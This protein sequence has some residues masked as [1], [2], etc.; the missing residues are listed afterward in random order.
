MKYKGRMK[1]NKQRF[2]GI[3]QLVFS[4]FA[5]VAVA[6]GSFLF[7][8]Y[9]QAAPETAIYF[10]EVTLTVDN[11][12]SFTLDA[13]IDPGAN[14]VYGVDVAITF[15]PSKVHVTGITRNTTA[16]PNNDYELQNEFDNEEGTAVISVIT[17]IVNPPTISSITTIA[18][19]AFEAVGTGEA[20]ISFDETD[21]IA[22]ATNQAGNTISERTST[23]VTVPDVTDPAGYSVNIN[24]TTI[25]AG[26]DD[27][28]SFTFA[29]AEVGAT[30]NYSIND[31]NGATAAI[32]GTGT[33]ATATDAI[34]NINVTSLDDDTL[35]L[36]VTLTDAALN[37]GDPVTDTVI[38][39]ATL[40]SG[41]TVGF[42]QASITS[43]NE[44]AASFTFAAAEVGAIYNYS[45]NDT[46]GATAAITGTGTIASATQQ[47]SGI[48]VS[49]LDDGTLT[50]TVYL[51]DTF[52]NQ[53][54]N[55][56]DTIAK[57]ADA[58]SGYSVSINQATI[59][60]GNDDALSFTFAA[61]E[62]DATYNYS[63][64]DTNGATA[65]ITGTGTIATATDTISNINVTSLDDGTLTL[66]V[67]LTDTGLNQGGNVTDTVAKDT[68]APAGYSVSINQA[69]INAGNDDALSFTFAA[70]EVGATYNYSIN[71]TNG[72]TAAITGTG[73]IATATD[74]ISNIN[75]TSLDD[76]TLTLT[77]YLT[78]T[79]GNQG[80]NATDTV[81]KDATAPSGYSV[82]INQ[83]TIN[84][85]ND[86]ALSFTFA[87]AEVGATYNYSI[88]DTNGATA[89][90]T[91]TG[92]IA[93]AT[94]TISNINVTSLS[95][96]TLTLTV[97]LTDTFSNQGANTTDTIAKDAVAPSGY[98]VSINQAAINAGNDDALS[99]TFA[100]AEVG[101]SYVYSIN[102]TNGATLPASG[103]GLVAGATQQ[104]SNI[105]V[106]ALD[107]DTLT[108]TVYLI[109]TSLNQ[110]SNVTDTV[111]KD[112]GIPAG[113]SVSFDQDTINAGS[114]DEV[115]FT[116]A[117][118]EVG[119]TYNYSINDTNGATAAITGT[120][121]IA[122]ATDQIADIDVSS[123]DDD[124][125]T[126][127]V[128]LT[129]SAGNQGNNATDTAAK[130]TSV[131]VIAR[132]T[133]V[134]TPTNDT[135][136]RYVFSST[137][138]GDITYGGDCS[139]NTLVAASGN[140]AI[141][142]TFAASAEGTHSNCTITV[143][144]SADNVSNTLNVP[145]FTIDITDPTLTQVAAV[146]TPT[147]DNTPSYTFS[148]DEAGIIT[149]G[150]DCTASTANA[151]IGNNA[152]VFAALSD[153]AHSN[154]TII[155]TDSASNAS[156]TL[157]I[158][159]FTV[160]TAAPVISGGLPDEPET[161]GTVT[162]TLTVTTGEVAVCRYST[163]SDT[164]YADMTDTLTTVG[165]T[166]HTEDV[167]VEDGNYYDYYVRCADPAGNT[168][169]S[170]YH[171]QFSVAEEGDETAPVLEETTPVTT[172]TT[173]TTPDYTF[174]SDEAGL[175][176]YD[177]DCSSETNYAV[178]GENTVTFEA[179]STGTYEDCS[180]TV[181][182]PSGNESDPL[183]I[184]SFTVF[185][186]ATAVE[187]DDDDDDSHPSLKIS[188]VKY[189]VV[190]G[191]QIKITWKTNNK[192]N[193]RVRYG[194]SRNLKE[195]KEEKRKDKKDH[196]MYLKDLTPGHTYYFRVYSED[197]YDD[198]EHS[199]TYSLKIPGSAATSGNVGAGSPAP[200]NI[201]P[202]AE[203]TAPAS[204][205]APNNSSSANEG[206]ND[207]GNSTGAAEEINIPYTPD[208]APTAPV[209]EES[210][211]RWWN[212]FT[213]F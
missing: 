212:P 134:A 170:D 166:T 63:I 151:S 18:T 209:S 72:A 22:I 86:D 157:S 186:P 149:Y 181:T 140:N 96:G 57:D 125:L 154:C 15:D 11:G 62:V 2:G 9:A 92:T 47:I 109:D 137:E 171:I 85:G 132:V 82:N 120:G 108:L 71:D 84:A 53:G 76:G 158:T 128:Y 118:A 23:V 27:A 199:K 126:L 133:A 52:S 54:A 162:S 163:D 136:P 74:T 124:T 208:P 139:S 41:Y 182:D 178:S 93:T 107:D 138:A 77:V 12:D 144:D 146:T 97:Y 38:K 33:I 213:W 201:S 150:G 3:K 25:N 147:A 61:A 73:T 91:G 155:V 110:G 43:A 98:S 112:T 210:N 6:Y 94:D 188:K 45:I 200:A 198:T 206:H 37:E 129:D 5:I 148:S 75:V 39:D 88:N 42:D 104:I 7:F 51:T 189:S 87:A 145:A 100:A 207:S 24:Q 34:S 205:V 49:S 4:V 105:D 176:T 203:N 40:P 117:A 8:Y 90:I 106:S 66:T 165:G 174:T 114:E 192:A 180:L 143:T 13:I 127:T 60:A 177:G 196:S 70:A 119:T 26:N 67:Y 79:T 81:T 44:T 190:S 19:F 30:Y 194:L 46:N 35:T 55:A 211:F 131:P 164:D 102:D 116:F 160:D 99:F 32:T 179:L 68:V 161:A 14:L 175:I 59:N 142:F 56:T 113:Y 65:A 64:N 156:N 184:T 16:F 123:L 122:T 185:A 195:E 202:S 173:D 95:D 152:V 58:P 89:A 48:N 121:T 172:P 21:T 31:T 10:D 50:L 20:T 153:G 167:S 135:T 130:S 36:T 115:S 187:D 1:K 197:K 159:A 80:S 169:D 168:T 69:T 141:D 83:A 101:A 103:S 193:E 28:L 183:N 191:N 17:G 29:A 111:A 204:D 78:D